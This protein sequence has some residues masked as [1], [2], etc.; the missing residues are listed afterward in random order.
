MGAKEAMTLRYVGWILLAGLV[1]G[2]VSIVANILTPGFEHGPNP[3]VMTI[4]GGVIGL[5]GAY[6]YRRD[7]P[8]KR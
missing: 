6:L 3:W 5:L 2:L 8:P 1:L 4:G 7:H